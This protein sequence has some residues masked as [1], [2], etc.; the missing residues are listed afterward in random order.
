MRTAVTALAAIAMLLLAGCVVAIG[1]SSKSDSAKQPASTSS[2][3]DAVTATT[4]APRRAL[5]HHV[6]FIRLADP[7]QAPE[8]LADCD[9]LLPTIP[10]VVSY[11]RGTHFDMG[12]TNVIGD[13]AVGLEVAFESREAYQTYL[14]HPNHLEL[15]EIWKPRWTGATIYDVWDPGSATDS[16]SSR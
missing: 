13:Y 7:S 14:D 2:T 11:W 10:G 4:T 1:N 8:L 6:V 16:A 12:R 3:S 15:L 9:R 5:I